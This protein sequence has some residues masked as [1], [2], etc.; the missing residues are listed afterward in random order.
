MV[1]SA[2]PFTASEC[3]VEASEGWCCFEYM[4]FAL[5]S[6]EDG[7]LSVWRRDIYS[8]CPAKIILIKRND[9]VSF[10]RLRE[11]ELK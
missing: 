3:C 7:D 9:L 5:V 8:E 10:A 4:R 11:K 2:T 1:A 6:C